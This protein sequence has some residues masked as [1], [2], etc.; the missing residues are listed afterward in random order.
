[1]AAPFDEVLIE[2]NCRPFEVSAK[3]LGLF[4]E[5]T[6]PSLKNS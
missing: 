1:M 6:M 3:N 2:A 5:T 4:L